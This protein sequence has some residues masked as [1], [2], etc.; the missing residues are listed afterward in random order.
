[1]NEPLDQGDLEEPDLFIRLIG[2]AIRTGVQWGA[3]LGVGYVCIL[4]LV[5][6]DIGAVVFLSVFGALF[7]ALYGLVMSSLHGLMLS[8][9]TMVFFSPLGNEH[10]YRGAM[11]ATSLL[12]NLGVGY[13]L[14]LY[15]GVPRSYGLAPSLLSDTMFFFG[16]PLLIETVVSLAGSQLFAL[17]YSDEC[18]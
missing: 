8:L 7:G 5:T 15:Y 1:M 4:A 6:G 14:V 12:V 9:I 10:I 16:W 17:W 3:A 13:G 11:A 2:R 18:F